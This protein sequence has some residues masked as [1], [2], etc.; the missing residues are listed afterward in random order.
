[1]ILCGASRSS[2]FYG[3]FTISIE[4]GSKTQL[5]RS[6]DA[7]SERV[8]CGNDGRKSEGNGNCKNNGYSRFP[9]RE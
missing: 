2:L 7:A 5:M 9:A 8:A 6:I 3:V 4:V 1:M